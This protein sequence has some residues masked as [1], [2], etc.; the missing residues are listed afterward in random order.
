[1][2][3]TVAMIIDIAAVAL[4]AVVVYLG[5]LG[6]RFLIRPR[7]FDLGQINLR[8]VIVIAWVLALVMLTAGWDS[9]G[10]TVGGRVLGL[11]VTRIGGGDLGFVRA[12]FRAVLYMVFPIGLFWCAFSTRQASI[13]DLIVR[14]EVR[15][16]WR[17]R[18][19]DP[20]PGPSSVATT[21]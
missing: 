6:I 4:G 17:A 20:I 19:D 8:S 21:S 10:R 13:Q 16:D 5:W 12:L 11:R 7:R 2:T 15:Y 14:T 1:V 18:A 3:R 9:R